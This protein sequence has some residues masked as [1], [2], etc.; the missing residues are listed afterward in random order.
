MSGML[1]KS[2]HRFTTRRKWALPKGEAA[3]AV[4]RREAA[5][6]PLRRTAA[7]EEHRWS[8]SWGSK[9]ERD[10]D[11]QG[12]GRRHEPSSRLTAHPMRRGSQRG[13]R[14]G[15][16][17]QA[18]G[19]RAGSRRRGD[20]ARRMTRGP[21]TDQRTRR[22]SGRKGSDDEPPATRRS[23][24]QLQS[25]R[26]KRADSAANRLQPHG[27]SARRARARRRVMLGAS[28]TRVAVLAWT[29][30]RPEQPLR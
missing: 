14:R 23:L 27:I 4:D 12:P 29:E 5:S 1:G 2:T 20:R 6:T 13:P 17:R 28:R 21:T 9:E 26:R 15:R 7:L 11:P 30:T 10:E 25:P 18:S 3:L 24:P 19:D 22:G 16:G 8:S